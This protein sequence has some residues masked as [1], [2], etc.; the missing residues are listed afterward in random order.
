MKVYAYNT[1]KYQKTTIYNVDRIE[2]MPEPNEITE[3]DIEYSDGIMLTLYC[4]DGRTIFLPH[5]FLISIT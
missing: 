1:G 2:A 4:S 5:E 3:E